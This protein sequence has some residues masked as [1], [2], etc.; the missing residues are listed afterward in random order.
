MSHHK[1]QEQKKQNNCNCHK[2]QEQKKQNNCNC[3]KK[4]EQQ[5]QNN[6]NCHKKQ[7]HKECK[8][9][10]NYY[11]PLPILPTQPIG[12]RI[13]TSSWLA[14]GSVQSCCSICSTVKPVYNN[15]YDTCRYEKGTFPINNSAYFIT[16]RN[17][18]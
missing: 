12:E 3:H 18:Y 2:K 5:K 4:Q 11:F 13:S 14:P 10:L 9:E 1:K 8:C 7:E 6:C 16:N 15:N 17:I